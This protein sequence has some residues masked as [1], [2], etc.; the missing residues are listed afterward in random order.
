MDQEK[1]LEKIVLT[2]LDTAKAMLDEYELV[3]PFGIRAYSG[4]DDLKMNCP[5][6][7]N[8][9]ADWDEQIDLVVTELKD[10]KTK[11][12]ISATALVTDLEAEDQNGIGVQIET[13]LSSVLFIYPYKKE[14]D[15][16]VIEEPIQTDQLLASVYSRTNT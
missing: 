1:Q 16:W 4:S 9:Q 10:F 7:K 14:K 11:E 12:K 15:D 5:A 13:D 3:L 8:P 2:C 6:D